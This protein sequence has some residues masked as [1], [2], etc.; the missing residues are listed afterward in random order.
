MFQISTAED[1]SFGLNQVD[2][3]HEYLEQG[4]ATGKV[5]IEIGTITE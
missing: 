3:A 1:R 4:H 5:L 2:K